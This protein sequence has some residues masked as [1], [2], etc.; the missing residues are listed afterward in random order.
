MKRRF[1]LL[2][3]ASFMSMTAM[4]QP[5]QVDGKYQI[6]TKAD[7]EW[8]A[9]QVNNG[10]S[11]SGQ[12]FEQTADIDLGGVQDSTG[13]WSGAQWTPIGNKD[14]QFSGTYDGNGFVICNLYYNNPAKEYVGLFGGINNATLKNIT[15]ASGFV[16][17]YQYA[18]GICGISKGESKI[19]CCANIATVYGKMERIGGIL[20]QIDGT[21]TVN[22]CINYGI[23]SAFNFTG[24]VIGGRNK[25]SVQTVSY[26]INVGQVFTMRCSGNLYGLNNSGGGKTDSCYYDNQINPSEGWTTNSKEIQK[27]IDVLGKMEGKPTSQMIGNSLASLLDNNLWVFEDNMYPR[28]KISC[29]KDAV[30]LAATPVLFN[31]GDK[32]DSVANDFTVSTNNNVMWKSSGVNETDPSISING[33]KAKIMKS[34][35]VIL[36]AQI[37]GNNNYIKRVYLRTEKNNTTPMGTINA[38]LPIENEADLIELQKAMKNYGTYKGCANYDGFKGLY[39]EQKNDIVLT[40]LW[41][42]AIGVHNSFKGNYNGCGNS[43]KDINVD[44]MD[45]GIAIVGGLF[46]CASYGEIKNVSL[47]TKAKKGDEGVISGIQFVGGICGATFCEKLTNCIATCKVDIGSSNSYA[48]G[49]VGVDKG[50]SIFSYCE[51]NGDISGNTCIGGILGTSNIES[52]FI[53]CKNYGNISGK[54]NIAGICSDARKNNKFQYCENHDTIIATSATS[55]CGGIIGTTSENEIIVN[56]CI[57]TQLINGSTNN[58]GIIG[59]VG[60]ATGITITNCLNFGEIKGSTTGGIAGKTTSSVSISNCFNAGV[61]INAI[62]STGATITNCINIGNVTTKAPAGCYFDKQLYPNMEITDNNGLNTSEMTGEALKSTLGEDNWI[63]NEGMYPM[64]KGLESSDYMKLAATALILEADDN[65]NSVTKYFKIG[66]AN[67]VEWTCNAPDKLSFANGHGY[68]TNHGEQNAEVTV[69][70]HLGNIQKEFTLTIEHTNVAVPTMAWNIPADLDINYGDTITEE[71]LGVTIS[72][73][74]DALSKGSIEYSIALGPCTL[75]ASDEEHTITATFVP[76]EDIDD[77]GAASISKKMKVNKATATLEWTPEAYTYTYGASDNK[78]KIESAVAKVNGVAVEGT[79]EYDI[80]ALTVGPQV[81]SIT[82]FISTNYKLA[83][84]AVLTKTINV[85][86][87]AASISWATPAS[88]PY[89]TALTSLQLS[90]FSPIEGSLVYKI[91]DE[92]VTAESGKILNGGS[93]TITATLTPTSPNY[94]QATMSV[95]LTVDPILPTIV[96]ENPADISFGTL[97]SDKQLNAK[98]EGVSGD[99]TYT[100]NFGARLKA[101]NNIILRVDFTPKG[102]DA[103]NY[104]ATFKEVKINVNKADA[105]IDWEYPANITYGTL[106]SE[107]QLNANVNGVTGEYNYTPA[108]GAKLNAGKHELKVDFTPTGDDINNCNAASKT[109][110][111]TVDKATPEITW[112]IAES[113]IAGTALTEDEHLNE[114]A[115]IGGSFAYKEGENTI[116][117]DDVLSVGSHQLTA[118]F[119]PADT[120]N[121]KSKS[122]SVTVSVAAKTELAITWAAPAPIVYGTLIDSTILNATANI[123]GSFAYSVKVGDALNA[124]DHAIVATF[125]PADNSYSVTTDTVV[126]QVAKANLIVSVADV[127]VKQGDALPTFNI[128]YNGFKLNDNESGLTSQVVATSAA[129]TDNAG[130]FDIVL[131]GGQSDNYNFEYQNGKLTITETEDTTAIVETKVSIS[132]YP[133]PTADVFFVETDSNVE[134]IF[135]YNAQGAL[136][137]VEQNTGKTRI[138]ISDVETGTY[139]VK[140]AEKTIKLLKF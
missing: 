63:F 86:P 124:G 68:V 43:I 113:I 36:T 27:N 133:N 70:V 130:T 13:I 99:F 114:K 58:G 1:T 137:K 115:N 42:E 108:I 50:Y 127:T 79:F 38:P 2:A 118:I 93:H 15:L 76:N 32:A 51:N 14:K 101:E 30:I 81:V 71:M 18:G 75:D 138:D 56:E 61:A 78:N 49:I 126:L 123:D 10:T 21:S 97:L 119:T 74:D 88:I 116:N 35:G 46:N 109:V 139:F 57:N 67:H 104:K 111:L 98:V 59:N 136:I 66:T 92:V 73:P 29:N 24:G 47:V 60:N 31:G 4:G 6:A 89:G 94:A 37:N 3:I 54:Q 125:T 72:A 82:N 134:N 140:V 7:L 65:V 117:A 80:P 122:K 128:T 48:G 131:S 103:T 8:L 23:I 83:N 106:L 55:N 40:S 45:D 9:E 110:I 19:T 44:L 129:S 52:T 102:S 5:S 64:P 41:T 121:Y 53:G 90:A 87:M 28:L 100:P 17:G 34:T 20:A 107:T 22:N 69:Y 105:I 16:Y 25:N 84:D 26:C 85:A 77:L 96:W 11:F 95:T 91:G 120:A 39:F 62:A 132:V 12:Q 33:N 112:D 135:I